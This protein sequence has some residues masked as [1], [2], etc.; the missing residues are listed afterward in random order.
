[1][2]ASFFI[3]VQQDSES[4]PV[5]NERDIDNFPFRVRTIQVFGTEASGTFVVPPKAN[6]VAPLTSLIDG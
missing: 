4:Q 6:E 5:C 2:V 1:M 3:D